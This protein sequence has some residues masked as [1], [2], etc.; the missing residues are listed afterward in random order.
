MIFMRFDNNLS[1]TLFQN[2]TPNYLKLRKYNN[3]TRTNIP[4]RYPNVEDLSDFL[5]LAEEK[6]ATTTIG[7]HLFV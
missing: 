2:G 7:K 1:Q 5:A 4:D 6:H 3:Q